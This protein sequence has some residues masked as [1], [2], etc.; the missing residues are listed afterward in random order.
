MS[1]AAGAGEL[2]GGGWGGY[3]LSG[4]THAPDGDVLAATDS[5]NGQWQYEYGPLNRLR[6]AALACMAAAQVPKPLQTQGPSLIAMAQCRSVACV[7][8]AYAQ[9]A[10]LSNRHVRW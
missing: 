4:V 10:H 9:L 7:R 1:A 8:R 5:V 6:L 3:T 2:T